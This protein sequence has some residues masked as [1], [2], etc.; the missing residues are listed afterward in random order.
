MTALGE[1]RYQIGADRPVRGVWLEA[2]DPDGRWDDNLLEVLPDDPQTICL[3][4]GLGG[5]RAVRWYGGAL[6]LG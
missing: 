4:R 1:G 3:L 6:Q 5:V 2:E